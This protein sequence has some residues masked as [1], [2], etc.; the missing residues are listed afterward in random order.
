MRWG[1]GMGR[2]TKTATSRC[3]CSKVDP[4]GANHSFWVELAGLPWF[5]A[6][7]HGTCSRRLYHLE[8]TLAADD[9][10]QSKRVDFLIQYL[11]SFRSRD[12]REPSAVLLKRGSA[13][14][15]FLSIGG[16]FHS[17]EA[18]LQTT[19]GACTHGG[20]NDPCVCI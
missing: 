8:V 15:S 3:P 19:A 7:P 5:L 17:G 9:L 14:F 10:A 13:R 18:S 2:R 20:D 1:G 6:L 4:A 11:A 12:S 16:G